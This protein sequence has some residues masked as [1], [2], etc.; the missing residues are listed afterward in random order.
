MKK[1]ILIK[2]IDMNSRNYSKVIIPYIRNTIATDGSITSFHEVEESD[3]VSELIINQILASAISD[4]NST[5]VYI[6][7]S[8]NLISRTN[9][10]SANIIRYFVNKGKERG[11]KFLYIGNDKSSKLIARLWG[12]K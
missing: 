8:N 10:Y 1:I 12:F 9:M 3:D 4:N 2:D 5:S 7:S 6:I 11:D